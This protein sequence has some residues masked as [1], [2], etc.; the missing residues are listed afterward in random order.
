MVLVYILNNLFLFV[1]L[2]QFLG[3]CQ[4]LA[5]LPLD[6]WSCDGFGSSCLNVAQDAKGHIR[7]HR[8]TLREGIVH[9]SYWRSLECVQVEKF[10]DDE[11]LLF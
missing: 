8:C 6:G 4:D 10:Y 9:H 7:P 11:Y 5:A 3:L 1:H 2:A